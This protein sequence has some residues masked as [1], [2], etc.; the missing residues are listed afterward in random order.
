MKKLTSNQI[1]SMWL[2]FFASKGHFIEPSASLIPHNDPTLLWINSGVAALKKYFDGSEIAKHSRITNAQKSIR[3]NDIDNVGKTARHHTFFEMLGNFSIGDYFR[4]EVIAWAYE[5]LF[6][7][8]YF[9]IEKD[10][11]YIT[12]HPSDEATK[13]EW[14]KQGVAEDHLIPL[15]HNFW[16]IGEGPCG[17]NT[18]MFYDRGEAYDPTHQGIRLLKEDLENDRYIEIWNIVFSQFNAESGVKRE[19][20]KE[21]PRK[22]IDTGAGLERIACVSQNTE[23]NFETDLFYPYIEAVEKLTSYPYEGDYK[24]AYRVIAD[25]IRT[26]T[27]ALADGALFSNEG[28]GYVLRRILRRAV[29]YGRKLGINRPFLYELVDVVCEVMHTYYP[30]LED[31]KEKV[32]KMIKSEEEKFAAT[33]NGG[34]QMLTKLLLNSS[35]VLSGIDAFK[36]YDTYGFPI[37]LTEEICAEKNIKIDIEAFKVEMEKQKERARNSRGNLQSMNK[38]SSDLLNFKEPSSFTYDERDLKAKVIG[39]FKDGVKVDVIEDE[40][41]VAFDVTNFYATSGGQV[42]DTGVIENAECEALVI[43]VNKSVNKQN[44]H[45]VNVKFGSIKMNDVFTLKIDREKREATRKNHSAVHLL[46]KALQNILGAH[47][48]QEGSF[49]SSEYL[50][51]DFAH[52]EKISHQQLN[53]IEK[54][55]N[56]MIASSLPCVI[57]EMKLEDA[58]KSG[59]MALFSE[60]YDD[61]V[62]V[63]DFGG[64][65]R[66]LC[67]GTHV[68]NTSSIVLFVI[69]SEESVASGIRRIE[70]RTSLNA[71]NF[72]KAREE[73]LYRESKELNVGS[74]NEIE[75]KVRALKGEVENLRRENTKLNEIMIL[76]KAKEYKE[77]FVIG[78]GIHFISIKVTALKRESLMVIFDYLKKAYDDAIVFITMIDEGKATFL[79]GVNKLALQRFKAGD[80]VKHV[81]SLCDGSGGGRPD[82]AQGGTKNLAKIDIALQSLKE[83]VK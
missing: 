68:D 81:C 34:E 13:K 76:N 10:K 49:V 2:D 1:R 67:G 64:V 75:T 74:Y 19:N 80:L 30:Y 73:I 8:K 60:K 50:R 42:H 22:N 27:F 15:E 45:T 3:T 14:M 33:L 61:V 23:T 59:A 44:L 53:E 62:R 70:A 39:L 63:V 20:Y 41:E 5:L 37:E 28:R 31:K 35:G 72:I 55:V 6:D 38:Q 46:Q 26:C 77:Q 82:S 65:S 51:F 25:H 4:E 36:L 58:K 17:P 24:M 16:E 66:E 47:V 12:Y 78:N 43:D 69:V 52:F 56:E 21:L 29:R 79:C 32:S 9:A 11:L 71:Y 57:T 54:S 40:G 83:F 7:P 48:H 18:E